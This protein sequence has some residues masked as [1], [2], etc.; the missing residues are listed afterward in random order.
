METS[1]PPGADHRA[2]QTATD[3]SA[4]STAAANTTAAEPAFVAGTA[5]TSASI[6]VV[7]GGASNGEHASFEG[8]HE[9]DSVDGASAA[10]DATTAAPVPETDTE[11]AREKTETDTETNATTA[12]TAEAEGTATS[13]GEQDHSS[14]RSVP[15]QLGDD[16]ADCASRGGNREQASRGGDDDVDSAAPDQ[17]S[18]DESAS[19]ASGSESE[20]GQDEAHG[21]SRRPRR[22]EFTRTAKPA[23]GPARASRPQSGS[24]ATRP[25]PLRSV[26]AR[27]ETKPVLL[28]VTPTISAAIAKA[29]AACLAELGLDALHDEP[30]R[31]ISHQQLIALSRYLQGCQHGAKQVGDFSLDRL[32]KG[33]Q[34][35]NPPPPP[36]PSTEKTPEFLALMARLRAEQEAREYRDM[37]QRKASLAAGPATAASSTETTSQEEEEEDPLDPSLV[38]NILV[39]VIFTGFAIYWA[40]SNFRMPARMLSFLTPSNPS[41]EHEA[42]Y[43]GARNTLPARVFISLFAAIAVG[44]AEVVIY[45]SYLRKIKAAKARERKLVE[46][47]TIRRTVEIV[48]FKEPDNIAGGL[49]GSSAEEIWGRGA[50]GGVRRRVREH[51]DCVSRS[52]DTE[53]APDEAEEEQDRSGAE[54]AVG[55]HLLY[56][57][58]KRNHLNTPVSLRSH[59]IL[60]E[61]F[62]TAILAANPRASIS[63]T[64]PLSGT[65]RSAQTASWPL[66]KVPLPAT[67]KVWDKL[68]SLTHIREVTTGL[69]PPVRAA[70]P[71]ERRI[72]DCLVEDEPCALSAITQVLCERNLNIETVAVGKSE[73]EDVSRMTLVL[74]TMPGLDSNGNGGGGDSR[75]VDREL[76]A[77]WPDGGRKGVM[78]SVLEAIDQNEAG[79]TRSR[80]DSDPEETEVTVTYAEVLDAVRALK[81]VWS[82][83]LYTEDC[84]SIV[85]EELLL[86]EISIL[87]PELV[88]QLHMDLEELTELAPADKEGKVQEITARLTDAPEELMTNVLQKLTDLT[89]RFHG[90][91]LDANTNSIVVE[92]NGTA[93]EVEA[94]LR[95]VAAYGIIQSSRTA[96]ALP[97]WPFLKSTR[98][99][100]KSRFPEAN[101]DAMLPVRDSSK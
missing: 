90:R 95:I 57:K 3:R 65:V 80:N 94:Y 77:L 9:P 48:G 2:A 59:L 47:K 29:P 22:R 27:S 56:H 49:K 81:P 76:E 30:R 31:A 69:K 72:L 86:A 36:K 14:D 46:R 20:A 8:G 53:A 67:S 1:T 18:D 34:V 28:T 12:T 88:K 98:G 93:R 89:E 23:E 32:L 41:L 45:A 25:S 79:E 55:K 21:T 19:A 62:S 91:I 100:R 40:I 85:G 66:P 17:P 68:P 26:A 37:L 51:N 78:A 50:H 96:I 70:F 54:S 43:P 92:L 44:V 61:A 15:L 6:A 83:E 74:R 64:L 82:A 84:E 24:G 63:T 99:F 87:G 73:F 10:E 101:E 35:Y 60:W 38:V 97:R 16:A 4:A 39:S 11:T 42:L 71:E 33:S 52:K 75:S 13:F 5:I 7:D 58:P